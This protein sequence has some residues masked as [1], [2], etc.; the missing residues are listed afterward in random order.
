MG[1]RGE[2]VTPGDSEPVSDAW[3]QI[4]YLFSV[5]KYA[6]DEK[7]WMKNVSMMKKGK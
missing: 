3:T 5:E 6:K 2:D 7:E 1:I 4:S